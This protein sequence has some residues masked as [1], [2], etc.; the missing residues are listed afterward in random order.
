MK[1]HR[2]LR[3]MAA[4]QARRRMTK[5]GRDVVIVERRDNNAVSPLHT[6]PSICSKAEVEEWT[7]S[8]AESP[9]IPP[10]L[11]LLDFAAW[12]YKARCPS[13][14]GTHVDVELSDAPGAI[15]DAALVENA[16]ARCAMPGCGWSGRNFEVLRQCLVC[17]E[18]HERVV[19]G[20]C[21]QCTELAAID[22]GAVA[23]DE[24]RAARAKADHEIKPKTSRKT[25]PKPRK[26]KAKKTPTRKGTN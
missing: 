11:P 7:R 16:D 12:T 15:D 6:I 9:N 26:P 5:E 20:A 14:F 2:E 25:K 3:A 17:G 23:K 1:N 22:A 8:R 4:Q 24:L 19:D 13:C 21:A 18:T 10:P